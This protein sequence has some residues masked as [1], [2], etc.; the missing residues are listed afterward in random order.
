M[1]LK[2][3]RAELKDAKLLHQ[4]KYEAFL[5]LYKHYQDHDT[6]PA[7]ESI[8][9]VYVHLH[10]PETDYY[11][12]YLDET[13]VGGV[14]IYRREQGEYRISPL[15]VLPSY[16]NRGIA[17]QALRMV[18]ERYPDAAFWVLETILQEKGNCH[19][20]EKCGFQRIAGKEEV[21]NDN[22]T[23]IFYMKQMPASDKS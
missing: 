13:P 17:Q 16:Q 11:V 20:Y 14:R 18:F 8:D 7:N 22:L 3:I 1:N 12:I 21:I 5:P 15:F 23:L 6:N 19:L 2:L 10:Q 9:K 4:M